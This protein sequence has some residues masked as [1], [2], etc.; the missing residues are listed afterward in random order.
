MGTKLK[1]KEQ[2]GLGF[3]DLKIFNQARTLGQASLE[4]TNPI[5]KQPM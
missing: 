3:R 2:G 1:C 5:P 4:W